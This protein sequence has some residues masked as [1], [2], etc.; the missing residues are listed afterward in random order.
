MFR[1]RNDNTEFATLTVTCVCVCVA[2]PTAY[3]FLKVR[4]SVLKQ[5]HS[6]QIILW[7]TNS[8]VLQDIALHSRCCL[9]FLAR[10]CVLRQYWTLSCVTWRTFHSDTRSQIIQ[11]FWFY[12]KKLGVFTMNYAHAYNYPIKN[13]YYVD[14]SFYLSVI[15]NSLW[16]WGT[17]SFI[18]HRRYHINTLW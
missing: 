7:E 12:K 8:P 13:F 16:D 3:I 5:I 10:L 2:N 11:S 15:Y 9:L 1:E 14:M 4:C 18:G 6:P 17:F